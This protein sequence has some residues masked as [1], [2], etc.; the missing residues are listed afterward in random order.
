MRLGAKRRV[1]LLAPEVELTGRLLLSVYAFCFDVV[2]LVRRGQSLQISTP[3][4][5]LSSASNLQA[6]KPPGFFLNTIP[7]A[8]DYDHLF[9]HAHTQLA[10]TK[11]PRLELPRRLKEDLCPDRRASAIHRPGACPFLTRQ[12]QPLTLCRRGAPVPDRRCATGDTAA[13]PSSH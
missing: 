4:A 1:M 3:S 8:S 11:T 13:L 2:G 12:P 9:I 7:L 6:T 10:S 5:R